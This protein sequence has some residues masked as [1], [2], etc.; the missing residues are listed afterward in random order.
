LEVF[1]W[2]LPLSD[3]R[4]QKPAQ[5]KSDFFGPT[6]LGPKM[7]HPESS[8]VFQ[9]YTNKLFKAVY[10]HADWVI[11]ITQSVLKNMLPGARATS[12]M[13]RPSGDPP[14]FFHREP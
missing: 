4:L 3:Q 1:N 2:L 6:F 8:S 9:I 10:R 7:T 13:W 14:K 12:K 11:K 5:E